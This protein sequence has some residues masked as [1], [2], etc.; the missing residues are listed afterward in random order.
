MSTPTHILVEFPS[1]HVESLP[2]DTPLF[3]ESWADAHKPRE[4]DSGLR[5]VN[6]LVPAGT[7]GDP[8]WLVH[9]RVFDPTVPFTY[10]V[11]SDYSTAEQIAILG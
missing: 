4:D 10:Y 6:D 7:L 8:N 5:L 2:A 11:A 9:D 1:G 3:V